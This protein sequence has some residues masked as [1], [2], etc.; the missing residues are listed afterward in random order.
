MS[1]AV[2]CNLHLLVPPVPSHTL[3]LN[4][5]CDECVSGGSAK[6]QSVSLQEFKCHRVKKEKKKS[7][8]Q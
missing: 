4:L 2:A 6:V 8:H 3:S 5:V 7:L 1:K